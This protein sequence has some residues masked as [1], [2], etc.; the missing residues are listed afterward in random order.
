MQR[1]RSGR[2]QGSRGRDDP[3][4]SSCLGMRCPRKPAWGRIV[5]LFRHLEGQ[6]PAQPRSLQRTALRVPDRIRPG[7]LWAHRHGLS[8]GRVSDTGGPSGPLG[9]SDGSTVQRRVGV[10]STAMIARSSRYASRA[11]ARGLRAERARKRSICLAGARPESARADSDRAKTW[12]AKIPEGVR[13]AA[14][15]SVFRMAT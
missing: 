10:R 9:T 2:L 11:R 5:T 6:T 4:L 3:S 1:P 7:L 13:F 12:R 8:T 15:A 14:A